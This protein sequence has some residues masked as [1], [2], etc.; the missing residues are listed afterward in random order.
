MIQS[1]KKLKALDLLLK[2]KNRSVV[3]EAIESLRNEPPY[4]GAIGLLIS[5]YDTINDPA[6][7]RKIGEFMNDLKDQS[8]SKEVIDEIRKPWKPDTIRM[9][10]SSCWQSGLDYSAFTP[11]IARIFL[12]G[13]Y[14]TAVECFTVI[15]ESIPRITRD[16][17]D[18]IISII[19]EESPYPGDKKAPLTLELISILR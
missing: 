6:I 11:D 15:E 14:M 2:N 9:L 17:K 10:V 13:D 7:K 4:Q 8:K 3:S 18:E 1:G 5:F 19:E 12:K 16:I